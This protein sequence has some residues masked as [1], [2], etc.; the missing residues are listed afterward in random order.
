VRVSVAREGAGIAICVDDSGRGVPHD[1]RARVFEP[2]FSTRGKGRGDGLHM[3]RQ[4]AHEHGGHVEIATSELGG[5]SFRLMMP[6]THVRPEVPTGPSRHTSATW[7]QL[8]IPSRSR[9]SRPA[10]AR[11]GGGD[12]GNDGDPDGASPTIR[13]A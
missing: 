3:V 12:D 7:P 9:E 11:G 6:A 2:G 1:L 8:R 4:F 13:V 5:A 10:A